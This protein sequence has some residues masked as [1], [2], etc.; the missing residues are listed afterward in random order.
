ME[1]KTECEI[2]QDLLISYS[3]EVLNKESKK[4]VER[5]LLECEKCQER[6]KEIK[7]ETEKEK[8]QQKKEIDYLKKIRLK[9]RVKSIFGSML[10]LVVI[11]V[12]WYLYKFSILTGLAKKAEKQ[13]ESENF[14]IESIGTLGTDGE[15]GYSK[16]W[17][18]DGKYK[19]FSYI[20][21]DEKMTQTFETRYG[22]LREN[23]KEEYFV[24][25]QEKKVRKE[26]LTY[27]IDKYQFSGL[28]TQIWLSNNPYYI[29]FRLGAPFYTKISKDHKEIGRL[30]Y[31]LDLGDGKQ[32]VDMDTGLP[33]MIFGYRSDTE[34]YKNTKI[35]LKKSEGISEYHYEF[36][37]VTEEDV[38]MPDFEGYEIEEYDWQEEIEKL[39]KEH[40]K[41][42]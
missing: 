22:N 13:L 36:G 18:K 20:E 38:Q 2:V 3:D 28:G 31:V 5:H 25:E 14:Y 12:G 41:N 21:K 9:N 40:E 30:Y 33:I 7:S 6:L 35:P 32:W 17:Y 8:T 1:K 24:N 15:V 27:E 11:F 16:T 4:L 37:N 42:S 23:T 10:I 29:R 34:Y 39:V 19:M 26:K